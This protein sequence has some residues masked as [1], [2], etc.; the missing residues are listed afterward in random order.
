MQATSSD[1]RR[2]KGAIPMIRFVDR[3]DAAEQL[4]DEV[5]SC[6]FTHDPLVLALPRGGVPVAHRLAR[7]LHAELDVLVVR[8]LGHPHD[9]ELALGAIAW[10]GICV[11][12]REVISSYGVHDAYLDRAIEVET[13]ELLRREQAYRGERPMPLVEGRTVLIVDDGIATGA[14]M[15][16]AAQAVRAMHPR[17][18][19]LV[20]PVAPR[21]VMSRLVRAADRVVVAHVAEE[22]RAVGEF[23]RSFEA[24]SD[25]Q[26]RRYLEEA[27]APPRR[28]SAVIPAPGE[29]AE[30]SVLESAHRGPQ[31]GK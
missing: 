22:F 17:E 26:V 23:Y 2:Q 29:H 21:S 25:G 13:K 10:S 27:W 28:H 14:T 3:T 8:K 12:N 9:P 15:L 7:A 16:A 5:L 30:E 31:H 4:L 1:Q 11:L 18:I 19:V 24:V 6:T 20:A